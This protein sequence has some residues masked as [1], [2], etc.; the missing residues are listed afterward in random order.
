MDIE[1]K[2][3][4]PIWVAPALERVVTDIYE[5]AR[6]SDEYALVVLAVV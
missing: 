3:I 4:W 5:E 6:L 2:G 1:G